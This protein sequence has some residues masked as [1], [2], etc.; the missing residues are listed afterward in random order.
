MQGKLQ[1]RFGRF[2]FDAARSDLQLD[3]VPLAAGTQALDLLAALLAKPGMLLSKDELMKAAWPDLHVEEGNISV[4]IH[5]LRR[6]L[7]DSARPHRW[8]ATVPGRGYRFIGR[9]E[10]APSVPDDSVTPILAAPA[11]NLPATPRA[12]IGREKE[13]A[14]LQAAM[15]RHRL[16]TVT[17][18]GG[19]GKTR[20]ALEFAREHAADPLNK[21]LFLGLE[22]L[23]QK[24]QIMFRLA[25]G[26]G[27]QPTEGPNL[28]QA[29]ADALQ[30]QGYF[31]VL[32][33][34][35]HVL[36][37]VAA[38][39]EIILERTRGV[40]I[41]ATS[42]EALKLGGELVFTLGPLEFPGHAK[43]LGSSEI[44]TYAAVQLFVENARA[45][46]PA[47][48]LSDDIALDVAA[49]CRKMEGIPLALELAA[50]RLH[51]ASLAEL[52]DGISAPRRLPPSAL[53]GVPA[54]HRTV[55]A[56]IAW[57]VALLSVEERTALRRL[58]IFS[59]G[60]TAA[61]AAAVIAGDTIEPDDV[62]QLLISLWDK[63]LLV[64]STT[65]NSSS[66]F[67]LLESTRAYALDMLADAGEAAAICRRL[68]ASMVALFDR[69]RAAWPDA[70]AELWSAE[71]EQDIENLRTA[72]DWA[73]SPG[74][75][76]AIG[77]ALAARL[78]ALFSDR[79]ITQREFLH[80]A[81]RA[82]A[83]LDPSTP[84]QDRGWI[85][86]SASYDLSAG[87]EECAALAAQALA[88]FRALADPALIGLSAA[89]AAVL[90]AMNIGHDKA[91]AYL[92]EAV[93]ALPLVPPNR[94]RSAILL[95]VATSFATMSGG[96]NLQAALDYFAQALPIARAFNDRAQI[97]LIGANLAELEAK[98]GNY[99]SAIERARALAQ[100]SRARGDWRRLS[101]DLL[102]LMN[103]NLLADR[104]PDA[105][106]AA[107]EVIQLLIEIG[108]EHW[109]ADYGGRFAMLAARSGKWQRA[110]KLAGFSERYFASQ[111]KVRA[112]VDG[113]LWDQLAA[114]FD[115]AA[116]SGALRNADRLDLMAQGARLSLREALDIG[117]GL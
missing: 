70:D 6:T 62:T 40:S 46:D 8:I 41:L 21:I 115:G 63:S 104:V 54:R 49:I 28:A 25:A 89:R 22:G 57:S 64:R 82:L 26:L 105:K 55:E 87:P 17:G 9:L 58:G 1:Y 11:N 117:Q 83:G 37:E 112:I 93:A 2:W 107:R 27:V 10:A 81:E 59:G 97:A 109:G 24:D 29:L 91:R 15:P 47:F 108:D 3:G 74:G 32:D 51:T 100:H 71:F 18:P 94:Y 103:Y 113:H 14:A 12:I 61:G 68:A 116:A 98:L 95:N 90:L 31:L 102:N 20:L 39:V 85:L 4:Q 101:H 36:N 43:P 44:K 65:R 45:S 30:K 84:T 114:A 48:K 35:E 42:R 13:L 78:R 50:A 16:V 99:D 33:N 7:R 77:V 76:A 73:F 56:T 5:H 75:N 88:S 60:F 80:A 72:L 19:M 110:A 86:L 66:R 96:A 92:E 106:D 38:L 79:L 34:C 111:K 53:P 23:R 67:R 52:L 69:S